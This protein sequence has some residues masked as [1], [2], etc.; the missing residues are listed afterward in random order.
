MVHN[1]L[2]VKCPQFKF[3]VQSTLDVEKPYMMSLVINIYIYVIHVV[4]YHSIFRFFLSLFRT[5]KIMSCSCCSCRW[6]ETV[7]KMRPPAGQFYILQ[8]TNEYG[9][10][11]K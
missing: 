10:T 3:C 7:F 9:A 5:L 2:F 8:M 11:V 1:N 6:G 4:S